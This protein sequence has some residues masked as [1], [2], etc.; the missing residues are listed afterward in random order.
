MNSNAI[1]D[2][3]V[4]ITGGSSGI[5]LAA[6]K[7]FAQAVAEVMVELAERPRPVHNVGLEDAALRLGLRA[8]PSLMQRVAGFLGSKLWV[9]KGA[10]KETLGNLYE[11]QPPYEVSGGFGPLAIHWIRPTKDRS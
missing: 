11:S 2:S 3:V 5:G 1:R 4:V 6:A 9:R 8:A 10:A 7:N